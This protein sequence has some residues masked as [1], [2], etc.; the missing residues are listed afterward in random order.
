MQPRPEYQKIE[1]DLNFPVKCEKLSSNLQ[2]DIIYCHWHPNIEIMVVEKGHISMKI[3]NEMFELTEGD[4][5]IINPN[6][7]HYGLAEVGSISTVHYIILSYDIFSSS[8]DDLICQKYLE[9]LMS[10]RLLLPN[11]IKSRIT[12]ESNDPAWLQECHSIISTLLEYGSH[13]FDGREIAVQSAFL[14]LLA[15]LYRYDLLIEATTIEKRALSKRALSILHY[16][17]EHFTEAIKVPKLAD[18][19]QVSEDYFYKLFKKTTGTTPI[20]FIHQLRIRYAQQLLKTTDLSITD[21]GFQVGFDS[22]S[23][24]SKTYKKITGMSP[25]MYRKSF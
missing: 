9:P 12:T 10:G 14:M 20:L 16:F 15:F 13:S 3:D 6:Q 7:V 8:T 2:S 22:T 17:E 5:C 21:I 25:R 23:Y 11:Y 1:L 18:R 4:I 24:F 19:F